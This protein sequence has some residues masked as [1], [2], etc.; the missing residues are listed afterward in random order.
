MISI[1]SVHGIRFSFD[2]GLLS[3]IH[4]EKHRKP[5]YSVSEQFEATPSLFISPINQP[6]PML[7]DLDVEWEQDYVPD[8]STFLRST[9]ELGIGKRHIEGFQYR[10]SE[11]SK[12]TGKKLT[13]S[14]IASLS[15]LFDLAENTTWQLVLSDFDETLE[16]ESNR[17]LLQMQNNVTVEFESTETIEVELEIFGTHRNA[18]IQVM[19]PQGV[20][21]IQLKVSS[22]PV[23]DFGD[24]LVICRPDQ[25]REAAIVMSCLPADRFTPLVTLKPPP[26]MEEAYKTLY[27]EFRRALRESMAEIGTELGRDEGRSP[28][29]WTEIDTTIREQWRLQQE[30]T[31]FRSWFKHNQM[32]SD[33]LREIALKQVVF[34]FQP[35]ERDIHIFNP[36]ADDSYQVQDMDSH[37]WEDRF[38]LLPDGIHSIYFLRNQKGIPNEVLAGDDYYYYSSLQELTELAWKRL[39]PT[40]QPPKKTFDVPEGSEAFYLLGL[41]CA[42]RDKVPLRA[43]DTPAPRLE[44]ACQIANDG[45]NSDEA[46][47][48][49]NSGDATNVVGALY[50]HYRGARLIVSPLPNLSLVEQAVG[51][52]GQKQEEASKALMY[53]SAYRERADSITELSNIEKS[54]IQSLPD[55]KDFDTEITEFKGVAFLEAIRRY[56]SG[57]WQS[58]ALTDI[59]AAVSAQVPEYVLSG[60]GDRSLTVFTTGLPYSFVKKNGVDWSD[61][62]IGHIVSDASLIILSEIYGKGSVRSPITFNLIFDPGFFQTSETDDVLRMLEQHFTCS[63]LLQK[64]TASLL[65]L[66]VLPTLLPLE[67][68]FFNT[69]GTDNAILLGDM[70]LMDYKITQW[71]TL[72]SR[73]IIFNN[74]CLSWIGVGREFIRAGAR[75]YIG[76]LWSINAKLAADFA[77]NVMQRLTKDNAPVSEAIRKTCVNPS[78]ERSYIYVGTANACLDQWR[79]PALK[80]DKEYFLSALELLLAGLANLSER[81]PASYY[82]ELMKLLYQEVRYFT[83][84]LEKISFG[85]SIDIVDALIQEL[86]VLVENRIHLNEDPEYESVLISKCLTKLDKLSIPKDMM[87]ERR[88]SIY[89]YSGRIKMQRGQ[90]D[91]AIA[92]LRQ[93]FEQEQAS[94]NFAIPQ[95]QMMVRIFKQKGQWGQAKEAAL[96]AKEL[97]EKKRDDYDI[98]FVLGDLGQICKR[99]GEYD[100]AMQ[101]AIEGYEKAVRIRHRGEQAVFKADQAQ[102]LVGKK[103]YDEA[104]E[105]AWEAIKIHRTNYNDLG[106][107]KAYGII[108]IC[109]MNKGD[110]SNAEKYATIGLKQARKIG[111]SNE[112]AAFLMDF[113][114]IRSKAGDVKGG[115]DYYRNSAAIYAKHGNYELLVAIMDGMIDLSIHAGDWP[116]LFQTIGYQIAI[117]A[118]L[119]EVLQRIVRSIVEHIKEAINAAELRDSQLGL[120]LLW[121]ITS[122]LIESNKESV[123]DHIKFLAEVNGMLLT[124]LHGKNNEAIE[125]AHL[126]DQI[127]GGTFNL[128]A[129]VT[130]PYSKGASQ[131]FRSTE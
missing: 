116:L 49:E 95:L 103:N 124:W 114:R 31:P 67:T 6:H 75:G 73:P 118:D 54:I 63:I 72:N 83:E 87:L 119:H 130:S 56:L 8:I 107:I 65:S 29:E 105:V 86:R 66:Q 4:I 18:R 45:V 40:G 43:V 101:Y 121:Q 25:L 91:E 88:A 37:R 96:R 51:S 57:D 28:E 109:Y 117:C 62:A 89:Y 2:A 15:L 23:F 84:S 90:L 3:G 126:L 110:L 47:L 98:M 115:I 78:T 52:Y 33:I 97:A 26:I 128:E 120:Q 85:N 35:E 53:V 99:F 22:L 17:V 12:R 20:S 59:E 42:L 34:L 79:D 129:Y 80:G 44:N 94:G 16:R 100:E 10:K 9:Q 14:V 113:G 127:S 24:T 102:I 131:G 36:M 68:I 123:S 61:K 41:P 69:H 82:S 39:G 7:R 92:D 46:V 111:N 48:I 5:I 70:P 27:R 108:D 112:E 74:S 58:D 71:V 30:L 19:L 81:H 60:V 104:I 64:K 93:S 125:R 21:K 106:E 32:L 122:G 55:A 1:G 77:R 50:A 11:K 13:N 76:T 38:S